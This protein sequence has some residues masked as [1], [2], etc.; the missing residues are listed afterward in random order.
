M[1]MMGDKINAK[2]IAKA[3]GVN[4]I[5]GIDSSIKK[6]EEAKEIAKEIGYPIML[7]ASNGGGGRGMRIVY[8]EEDLKIE[9]ETAC[10]ESRKAFGEDMI[11]IEKYIS[12]P[13]HIEVQVLGDKEGN[14]VHLYERDCSV[15][16]RHQKIIE[17][18]PALS[19]DNDIRE[20]LCND[21]LKIANYVRYISAG[22]LEFLVDEN[23]SYYFIEMNPRIQVEHT[24]TEMITG[25][26]IVQSQILIAQGYSL[27]SE[28]VNIKSQEDIQVN[29]YSI[30]C[31]ITTED[32]K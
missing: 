1:N 29:G 7:K 20:N 4:T 8:N 27:N 11:F 5:P 24:V 15:Q 9:Y 12:N 17:Y 18:A 30:Q 32:P 14:I 19:L 31:R 23:G 22:T 2:K 3:V 10:S 16:R 13:K 21:A 25:I 26:D 6:I 28:E